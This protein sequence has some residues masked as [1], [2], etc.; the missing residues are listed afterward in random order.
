MTLSVPAMPGYHGFA[1][2][3]LSA[4]IALTLSIAP[5]ADA[6][7]QKVVNCADSGAG[8][9][10]SAITAALEGDTVDMSQL[11]CSS[12]TLT[13]AALITSANNL[14][15]KGKGQQTLTINGGNHSFGVIQHKGTGT[16]TVTDVTITNASYAQGG[17]ISSLGSVSLARVTMSSCT[18]TG[19]GGQSLGGAVGAVHDVTMTSCV[20]SNNDASDA[21]AYGAI[22]LG[23]AVLAGGDVT[24]TGSTIRA[25]AASTS[26]NNVGGG[27]IYA[28][29]TLTITNSTLSNNT[30]I[31]VN[32]G[33]SNNSA[34]GA[35]FAAGNITV[36][37]S[38]ID[39]NNAGAGGGLSGGTASVITVI[40]STI[41]GNTSLIG[42]GIAA[43]GPLHLRNSTIAMNSANS[44]NGGGGVLIGAATDMQSTIIA[45]NYAQGSATTDLSSRGIAFTIAGANNIIVSVDAAIT[46]PGGTL[47]SDPK[48][49]SFLENNGG[50]TQ[51]LTLNFGSPAIGTGNNVLRLASDQRGAGFARMTKEKIDIG[52]FQTGD[53][54]FAS[55]FE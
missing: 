13:S 51:T 18:A 3:S 17:C 14:T 1:L 9:L 7:T 4:C 21:T 42:G 40:N 19:A 49:A 35:A 15:I 30:A 29:G 12:I 22:A 24:V 16:L 27:G 46:L 5:M 47:R 54:I 38:T 39:S 41:S 20:L 11:A 6:A 43:G 8:S 26:H 55:G 48:L 34:G 52:A 32:L 45:K 37:G 44:G 23:G 36:I 31:D 33:G 2:R 25:N 53:G 50:S 10:R 28:I